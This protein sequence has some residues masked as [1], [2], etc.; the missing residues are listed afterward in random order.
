MK[1]NLRLVKNSLYQL[2]KQFALSGVMIKQFDEATPNYETGEVSSTYN[3]FTV[4]A[5]LLPEKKTLALLSNGS[6]KTTVEK[7]ER[8]L[9][10]DA[11]D[12]G[13]TFSSNLKTYVEYGGESFDVNEIRKT[14]D[15]S[16][17]LLKVSGLD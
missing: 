2:K 14:E 5:I 9:I 16:S 8:V 1:N 4:K 13:S 17:F 15:S 10:V 12:V 11:N 6:F 7:G 3:T